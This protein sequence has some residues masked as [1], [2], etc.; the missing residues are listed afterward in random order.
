MKI[1]NLRKD[2]AFP[3]GD[4]VK[5]KRDIFAFIQDETLNAEDL[6]LFITIASWDDGVSL[7]ELSK[8]TPEPLEVTTKILKKL[9]N[10][11][12]IDFE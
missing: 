6:G 5:Y 7:E 4:N 2:L 9:K 3:D 12:F 11:S 1:V 10:L 8:C